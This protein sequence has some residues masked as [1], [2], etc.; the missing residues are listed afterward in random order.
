[1]NAHEMTDRASAAFS[2]LVACPAPACDD[3]LVSGDTCEQ[4]GGE[5][6]VMPEP[7]RAKATT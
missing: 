2:R 6:R 3:G 4:C 7:K 1:M 5:G